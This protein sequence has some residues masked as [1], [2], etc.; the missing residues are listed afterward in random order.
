LNGTAS[1]PT[2]EVLW[3]FQKTEQT[4][5][6]ELRPRHGGFQAL[7]SRDGQPLVVQSFYSRAQALSWAYGEQHEIQRCV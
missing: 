2:P 6:C 4:W 3:R 1:G 5:A 7:I